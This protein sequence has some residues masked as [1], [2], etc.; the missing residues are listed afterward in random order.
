[1]FVLMLISIVFKEFLCVFFINKKDHGSFWGMP[2]NCGRVLE[3]GLE[4]PSLS[5]SLNT[6][7]IWLIGTGV[8][9]KNNIKLFKKFSVMMALRVLGFFSFLSFYLK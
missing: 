4:T 3:D 7:F 2:N 5:L 9:C 8:C 1:M 6:V